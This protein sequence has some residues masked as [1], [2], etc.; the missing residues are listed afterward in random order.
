MSDRA[1][2]AGFLVVAI[3][4]IAVIVIGLWPSGSPSSDPAARAFALETRLKCPICAGEALAGS[5]SAVARDLRDYIDTRIAEGASDQEIIDEFVTN[6]GEQILLDP[7]RTGWG[8]WLWLIPVAVAG[9]GAFA[10]VR[11]RKRTE[12]SRASSL[13]SGSGDGSEA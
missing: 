10:V 4:A 1:R 2:N 12:G 3:A 6:Y 5:Q 7:P 8:L 13:A 9:I 11:L